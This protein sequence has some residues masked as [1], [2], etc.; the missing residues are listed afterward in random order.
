MNTIK[1]DEGSPHPAPELRGEGCPDPDHPAT[2]GMVAFVGEQWFGSSPGWGRILLYLVF[3]PVMLLGMCISGTLVS[4]VTR[5][6]LLV[7]LVAALV[8]GVVYWIFL[9][10]TSRNPGPMIAQA[11]L[12]TGR[13][14]SCKHPM[15]GLP[16]EAGMTRCGECGAK[17]RTHSI[18]AVHVPEAD[19]L[20][21]RRLRRRIDVLRAPTIRYRD[22]RGHYLA[23]Q[24]PK[25][26]WMRG[27]P[28]AR[29]A[30]RV[31]WTLY[32]TA[33]TTAAL[34]WLFVVWAIVVARAPETILLLGVAVIQL[35]VIGLMMG[36]L[37]VSAL[38]RARICPAC[39]CP[40]DEHLRCAEC[41]A[42]WGSA[43]V[44]APP[45]VPPSAPPR[46]NAVASD[47]GA[48]SSPTDPA[49]ETS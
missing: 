22:A 43:V 3:V 16:S 18:R 23:V 30:R 5:S 28:L 10:L 20:G 27:T 41:C 32:L 44:A 29:A 8:A 13:C 9:R 31:R 35:V 49:S 2:R 37:Q 33:I 24:L 45:P 21:A 17:W 47:L 25:A 14:G 48:G 12:R 46:A 26:K 38:R 11:L 6:P 36:P 42:A 39:S 34:F 7:I 1:D 15:V 4:V 19:V 40:L